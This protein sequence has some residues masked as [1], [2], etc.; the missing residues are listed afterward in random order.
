MAAVVHVLS[1]RGPVRW[2]LWAMPTH[3]VSP[4]YSLGVGVLLINPAGLIGVGQR[5]PECPWIDTDASWHMP[6][7]PLAPREPV[8]DA[9]L[10]L[11]RE[12]A[13]FECAV[14]LAEAPGWFTFELPSRLVGLALEGRYLGQKLRWLLVRTDGAQVRCSRSTHRTAFKSWRWVTATE[15]AALAPSLRRELYDDVLSTF[16]PLLSGTGKPQR[17]QT[18]RLNA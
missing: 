6:Q 5:L 11:V 18:S 3:Y 1:I 14:L 16:A 17:V 12:D 13:G 9:A 10:R 15:V 2:V 7:G 4:Q 8:R